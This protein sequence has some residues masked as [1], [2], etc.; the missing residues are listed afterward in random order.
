MAALVS[1]ENIGGGTAVSPSLGH[2]VPCLLQKM[3]QTALSVGNAQ[4]MDVF[5]HIQRPGATTVEN[6]VQQNIL[7]S[8]C[9][10]EKE[11]GTTAHMP[12]YY[13][14]TAMSGQISAATIHLQNLN[15]AKCMVFA[16]KCG[17]F[18]LNSWV[19]APQKH[20]CGY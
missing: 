17:T 16:N 10:L 4:V 5:S 1:I 3:P 9:Q 12:T 18:S 6:K 8:S 11:E 2:R 14:P 13:L 20:L 15:N 19:V 7:A